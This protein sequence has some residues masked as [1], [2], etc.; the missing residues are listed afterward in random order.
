M[1]RSHPR[2]VDDFLG[3]DVERD[4][5]ILSRIGRAVHLIKGVAYAV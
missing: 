5:A 3:L 4:E 1:K 2:L